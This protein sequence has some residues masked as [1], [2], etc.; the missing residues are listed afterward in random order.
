MQL[1]LTTPNKVKKMTEISIIPTPRG[2]YNKQYQNTVTQP[3]CQPLDQVG[4][5]LTPL[6]ESTCLMA[7]KLQSTEVH[8]NQSTGNRDP[9]KYTDTTG[10]G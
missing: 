7:R 2:V 4:G 10:H 5:I 3:E 1:K 8:E 9:L 6:S